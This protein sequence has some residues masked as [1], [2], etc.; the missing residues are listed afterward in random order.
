MST[1]GMH[2][3]LLLRSLRA[4]PPGNF[5]KI[6]A[7]RL[8]L[9][10]FLG[11]FLLL[12]LFVSIIIVMHSYCYSQIA[13][14]GELRSFNSNL[15]FLT[16]FT[17]ERVAIAFDSVKKNSMLSTSLLLFFFCLLVWQTVLSFQ[18]HRGLWCT[19][20]QPCIWLRLPKILLIN[21]TS[22]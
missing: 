12:M 17:T 16:S 15:S 7:L 18:H 9:S 21:G 19:R 22:E 13:I 4:G 5:S 14:G 11:W 2:S 3:M 10:T 8:Y 1:P 6:D 20:I